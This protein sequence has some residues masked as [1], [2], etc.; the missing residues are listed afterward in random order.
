MVYVLA[1]LRN[2]RQLARLR[3]ASLPGLEEGL[4]AALG[5]GVERPVELGPGIWA[6]AL[7]AE[8]E[9]NVAGAAAAAMRVLAFLASRRGSLF[10]FSVLIAGLPAASASAR[11]A[12]ALQLLAGAD[13]EEQLWL[14][15]ESAALFA[16]ALS[17]TSDG[18][19]CRV[20]GTRQ[21]AA[22][23]GLPGGLR[24]WI[25]EPL[26][27]RA[28]DALSARL[29]GE[30]QREVLW[31]H[32]PAGVG[33]RALVGE[34]AARLA[35]DPRVPALRLRTIFKRRSPLHPFLSS[36]LPSVLE[37][38]PARLQGP[39][40]PVW[41]EVGGL[42]S[43][44]HDPAASE[45]RGEPAPLPDRILDD[46][47][48][49]YGLYLIAWTRMA[50]EALQPAILVCE[51]LDAWHPAA[52]RVLERL[53]DGLLARPGF[54]PI[55]VCEQPPSEKDL[56]GF[57]VRP[58][59]VHPLGKREIRALARDSFDGLE[60]SEAL[61]RRLRRRSGGRYVSA[62][63]YLQYLARTGAIVR[64]PGVP[65][66]LSSREEPVVPSNPLSVS[67]FLI[68]S[69]QDE[70]F[71]L[72]YALHL[73]GGLLDR[74]GF[75]SFLGEAGFDPAGCMRALDG[76]LASGLITDERD[77]IP[78]FPGLRRKLEELLGP[79]GASLRER[80]V[81]HMNGLWTAGRYRHPVLLFTFLARNGRT[82]LAV[83]LLPDIIRRKLDE[84]DPAG[85]RA[86][87][88]LRALE[89][90]VPPT[91]DQ[92]RDLAAVTAMG[93]LRAAL[94]LSD[95]EAADAAQADAR[96]CVAGDAPPELRGELHTERARYHLFKGD[97]TAALDELK[98]GLIV[99][100]D[101]RESRPGA[102]ANGR[103]E[104]ACYLWLGATMLAEGRL[105]EA[106][107]YLGLS[108][109]LCHEVS[110]DAG[111]L[112]TMAYLAV[113]HYIDG[114]STQAMAALDQGLGKARA[115][116]RRELE[117]A[118]QFMRART[119]FVTGSYEECGLCLQ[120]CLC[121]ATLYSMDETL[122]VLRAWL[123]RTFVHAGDIP[124]GTRLLDSLPEQTREVLL[125]QAEGA[126]FAGGLE[127]ASRYVERALGLPPETRFPPPERAPWWNGQAGMEG[128]CFHLSRGDALLQRTL[129]GLRAY[130]LGLRG[131][132][133]QAIKDLH[134]LTR[135]PRAV[136]DD[137][138]FYW[139]HYLYA[140]VLPETGSEEVDDKVTV[141]SK[142]LK[143][144]QERASRIEAPAERSSFL[145]RN[146]W[147]RMIMDEA[148]ARKLA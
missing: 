55:V 123:G 47:S 41:D 26:V 56:P 100:Q 62:V 142:S 50:E 49:A 76:L 69:L 40:R 88:D 2:Y 61:A 134:Q 38:A 18:L 90:A 53:L 48:L 133:A 31:V 138:G 24:P 7:G 44:L 12:R 25:R 121:L 94:L 45:A 74:Q 52:R 51:G 117:L 84:S 106:V 102:P 86:F 115:L 137:P 78:R 57:T 21:P 59:P 112:W 19:L 79:E 99:F 96:R 148:R 127:N 114:R 120:S 63:S 145:W 107:E 118:L 64:E 54:L 132:R 144:L 111:T 17:F 8:E 87:C 82:D 89:F 27:T 5:P 139:L 130:L 20:T 60:L 129:T 68:R 67:W 71:L 4:A 95:A 46:F 143:G 136:E 14:A 10:G 13:Q 113:C 65:A 23:D 122:P 85:A 135:G 108:Q 16:E 3:A 30:E 66:R 11:T 22:R 126:L 105:G 75:L 70:T 146:R 116:Y 83:R 98:R 73:S 15:S 32:G 92:A 119:L 72:L 103:A 131:F 147:N 28:L 124:S 42:L 35:R 33:K 93:R 141:L 104:R 77:L 37:R 110:D 9:I 91:P 101:A 140:Q 6:S 80:F 29:N 34:V 43:W 58:L 39:E 109:R 81:S 36:L 125:F 1:E 97:A 128:R